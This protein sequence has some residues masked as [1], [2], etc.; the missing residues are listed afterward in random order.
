MGTVGHHVHEITF[1]L[2]SFILNFYRYILFVLFSLAVN[3]CTSQ[4]VVRCLTPNQY[5]SFRPGCKMEVQRDIAPPHVT[6]VL[7]VLLGLLLAVLIV[8]VHCNYLVVSEWLPALYT[9]TIDEFTVIGKYQVK[10]FDPMGDLINFLLEWMLN[11]KVNK[12]LCLETILLTPSS[13]YISMSSYM[14]D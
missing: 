12:V 3:T 2:Y 14:G 11:T 4:P 6:Q 1:F 13:F 10:N 7:P 9:N 5:L 8:C